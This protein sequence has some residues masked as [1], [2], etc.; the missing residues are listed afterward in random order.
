MH[1]ACT[2][3]AVRQSVRSGRAPAGAIE[4]RPQEMLVE[5]R[6]RIERQQKQSISGFSRSARAQVKVIARQPQ[7]KRSSSSRSER[8]A[9][10]AEAR[11]ARRSNSGFS[12]S[13]RIYH[14]Q[15]IVE[16]E[17]VKRG[18][19]EAQSS[20]YSTILEPIGKF[21]SGIRGHVSRDDGDMI[22]VC[23]SCSLFWIH[24][25]TMSACMHMHIHALLLDE[26]THLA[27]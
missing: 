21:L 23:P 4:Q 24:T 17:R 2:N 19:E 27:P 13:N 15:K 22:I 3:T 5:K 7:Q 6:V 26:H 8:T 10:S 1:S 9:A 25:H 20:L 12:R 16:L 14:Q 11:R 18:V